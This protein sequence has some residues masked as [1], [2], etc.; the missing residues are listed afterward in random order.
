MAIAAFRAIDSRAEPS[1]YDLMSRVSSLLLT[2]DFPP[3][4]A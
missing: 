4:P 2:N 3:L 1:A